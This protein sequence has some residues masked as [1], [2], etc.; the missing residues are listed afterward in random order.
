MEIADADASQRFHWNGVEEAPIAQSIEI[1]AC[2]VE[3][4]GFV[5]QMVRHDTMGTQQ[6]SLQRGIVMLVYQLYCL[7]TLKCE[8]TQFN[9]QGLII[10]DGACLIAEV[11]KLLN[12]D[13]N[14]CHRI[15]YVVKSATLHDLNEE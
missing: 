4:V 7:M 9:L 15:A 5:S 13:L 11:G 6:L 12:G 14:I 1:V 2:T 8:I 10:K 3:I